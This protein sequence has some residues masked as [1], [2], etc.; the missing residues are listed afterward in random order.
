MSEALPC[1]HLETTGFH[2]AYDFEGQELGRTQGASPL[3]PMGCRGGSVWGAPSG[4][5][6][7]AHV[8]VLSVPTRCL[9]LQA[10]STWLG[11]LRA[12]SSSQGVPS[13]QGGWLPGGRKWECPASSKL[14][15]GRTVLPP[16]L[17]VGQGYHRGGSS[18]RR[19]RETPISKWE[20]SKVPS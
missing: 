15:P 20:S 13:L 12:Q 7:H 14:S 5:L 17:P 2:L 6:S 19:Q 8:T 9:I 16:L 4:R 18:S 1:P 10:L 11:F 3:R